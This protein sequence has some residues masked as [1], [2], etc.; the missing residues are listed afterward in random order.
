MNTPVRGENTLDSQMHIKWAGLINDE[1][2]GSVVLSYHLQWDRGSN[3]VVWYDL[4]GHDTIYDSEQYTFTEDV[5]GGIE[6]KFRVRARNKWGYGEWSELLSTIA[7]NSPS[8]MDMV[9]TEVSG[10]NIKVTWLEPDPGSSPITEYE[11]MFR[12]D[13]TTSDIDSNGGNWASY[14]ATCLGSDNNIV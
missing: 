3:G 6:Y 1:T 7:A 11:I 9:M 5:I 8:Q 14:D 13:D 2:G 12:Y 4:I 10:T